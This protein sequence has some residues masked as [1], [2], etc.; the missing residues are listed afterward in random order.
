L[1]K[2]K[3]MNINKAIKLALEHHRAGNLQQAASLYKKIA[4]KQPHNGDIFHMLGVISD[5]Q[6]DLD[7]SIRYMKKAIHL[8]PNNASVNYNLGNVLKKKGQIDE[9]IECYQKALQLNPHF[10]AA[11][12]NLG[13]IFKEK[14]QLDEAVV[15]YQKIIQLNPNDFE[16]YNNLGNTLK[17]KGELDGAM[18]CYQKALQLSPN[19]ILAHN[20]L[21]TIYI[22][23]KQFDAA[24]IC[25]QKALRLNPNYADAYYNLGI[26][27]SEKEQFDEAIE[28]YQKALQ[29]DPNHFNTFKGLGIVFQEKGQVDNALSCYQKALQ[30]NP[31]DPEAHW[32]KALLLLLNSH[33]KEGWKE[34]EWRW[35]TKKINVAHCDFPQPLWDGHDIEGLTILLYAE[36]GLGDTIQ[37]IRYASLVAQQGA[38]VIIECQKELIPLL[39]KVEGV[40][41]AV[42]FGQQL[43]EFDIHYPLLSLPLLFDTTIQTIPAKIPYIGVN[44]TS[45]QKWTS[46]IKAN[47][48][49]QKIGLVWA[50]SPRH[51]R[52]R[53]RSCPL[54]IFAPLARLS[55]MTFYSLQKGDAAEQAK[56]PPEGMNIVDFTED[57]HDFS[58]TA[59]VIE[60]LDLTISV[61]T[62]VAHL[63]GA[64]GKPVWTL[65]P[66]APD[67]RWMLNRADS[68]WYPTMR[69]FRQP[70][71][72]DWETVIKNIS[73]DLVKIYS[74]T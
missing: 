59:A 2:E 51:K 27:Y 7:A 56:N 15:C 38:K 12:C 22:E 49:K 60:N 53:Y 13:N 42:T 20:N 30:V 11:Y 70:S 32:N 54:E 66:F 64:M 25:Y 73:K 1:K 72:G 8:N 45:V 46:R 71:P 48:S 63:A 67:W 33:F 28:C 47:T 14:E 26:L 5:Q 41:K 61:D 17:T 40:Q 58:D 19:F 16:A 62:S 36:Q 55:N 57:I 37:F 43:L 10:T 74:E 9:A 35:K 6:E 4:K 44:A 69:L 34:F 68:P 3:I 29:L 50:G 31:N 39:Q 21:G 65:L 52:D 24:I 23:K 18:T